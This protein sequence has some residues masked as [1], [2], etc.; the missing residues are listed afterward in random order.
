MYNICNMNPTESGGTGK[1]NF[2][3]AL[4]GLRTVRDTV[5]DETVILASNTVGNPDFVR[6]A[7]FASR[8]MGVSFAFLGFFGWHKN[9]ET[10]DTSPKIHYPQCGGDC[11]PP[12]PT[13]KS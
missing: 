8:L 9:L 2:S 7:I 13:P 12:T 4:R 5:R 3:H 10:V 11:P 6:K 1:S